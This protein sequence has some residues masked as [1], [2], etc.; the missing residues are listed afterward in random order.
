M[1]GEGELL[2]LSHLSEAEQSSIL[3]VLLRDSELRSR[4][5]GRLRSEVIII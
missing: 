1:E 2:D 5:D 3:E 4:D